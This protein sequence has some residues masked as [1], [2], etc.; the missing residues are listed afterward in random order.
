MGWP[1]CS[2]PG[3]RGWPSIGHTG[4]CADCIK[5]PVLVKK[6]ADE[7]FQHKMIH[8][9]SA[10]GE[11]EISPYDFF[12]TLGTLNV[13]DEVVDYIKKYFNQHNRKAERLCSQIEVLEATAK[14]T[15]GPKKD[16]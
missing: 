9:M 8:A 4:V 15:R 16:E 2:V 5:D 11:K 3:C 14:R 10:P 7:A 1:P 12:K 13:S 6:V